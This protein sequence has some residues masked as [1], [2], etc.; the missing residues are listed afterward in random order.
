MTLVSRRTHEKPLLCRL[1]TDGAITHSHNNSITFTQCTNTKESSRLYNNN[2]QPTNPKTTPEDTLKIKLNL[3]RGENWPLSTDSCLPPPVARSPPFFPY[4]NFPNNKYSHSF[5]PLA[6]TDRLL[7]AFRLLVP[8][9]L[10]KRSI[11][12]YW[13]I[14]I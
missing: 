6:A 7:L 12:F 11:G 8:P 10:K 1:C 14:Y 13:R 3:Q 5:M 4:S 9:F 2:A